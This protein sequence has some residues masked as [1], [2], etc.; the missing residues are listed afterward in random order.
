M[1]ETKALSQRL[2][3]IQTE[4]KDMKITVVN[5]KKLN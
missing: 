5:Y 3:E 2:I 1:E 4:L